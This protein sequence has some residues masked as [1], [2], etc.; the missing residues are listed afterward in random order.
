METRKGFILG[1]WG[2][3]ILTAIVVV[4]GATFA[5]A[6]GADKAVDQDA[7]VSAPSAP[8][9]AQAETVEIEGLQLIGSDTIG[10]DGGA[11]G[12]AGGGGGGAAGGGGTDVQVA[13]Y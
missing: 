9:A 12:A 6:A 8:V 13:Q 4:A 5:G 2:L 10:G 3:A 1:K 7:A 11:G